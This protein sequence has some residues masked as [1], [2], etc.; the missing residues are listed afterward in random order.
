MIEI[1]IVSASAICSRALSAALDKRVP[2]M[3]EDLMTLG[4]I[5]DYMPSKQTS[6]EKEG[7]FFSHFNDKELNVRLE[8]K[9]YLASSAGSGFLSSSVPAE[10]L[11]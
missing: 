9:V 4:G 5:N 1:I 2:Q 11:L 10:A 8:R 6:Q 7:I 3:T